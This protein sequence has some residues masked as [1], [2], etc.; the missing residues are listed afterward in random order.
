MEGGLILRSEDSST[1]AARYSIEVTPTMTIHYTSAHI[2]NSLQKLWS[3]QTFEKGM[4]GNPEAETFYTTQYNKEFLKN[5]DNEYCAKHQHG[6][7]KKPE[8][9][10][11]HN[12]VPHA[13]ASWAG[14][15]TLDPH[16]LSS[17][18]EEYLMPNNVAETTLGWCDCVKSLLSATRLCL[19]S[20]PEAPKNWGHTNAILNEYLSNP[21]EISSKFRLPDL[22]DRWCWQEEINS[23]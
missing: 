16:N 1:E 19:R 20:P 11:Q 23:K 9:V 18:D 13:M 17:N 10:Q 4:D 14:Q 8:N 6:P 2:F 3:P 15:L 12:F 21:L 5:V 22:T 7:V